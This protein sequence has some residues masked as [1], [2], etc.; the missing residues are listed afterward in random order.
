MTYTIVGSEL[1]SLYNNYV[2]NW[3]NSNYPMQYSRSTN[4]YDTEVTWEAFFTTQ[5]LKT[6]FG[7][8]EPTQQAYNQGQNLTRG[9]TITAQGVLNAFSGHASLELT[10]WR[11]ISIKRIL[12]GTAPFTD[13]SETRFGRAGRLLPEWAAPGFI[14]PSGYSISRG[15]TIIENNL[16]NYMVAI[17]NEWKRISVDTPFALQYT[18][19]HASCHNQCHGS[20]GRR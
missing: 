3:I 10:R 14:N 11:N 12:T 8:N 2:V 1:R 4:P 15:N 19:C 6:V 20:R 17:R 13:T 5:E 9:N 7:I 16:I 18:I